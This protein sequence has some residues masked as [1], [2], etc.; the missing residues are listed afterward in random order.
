MSKNTGLFCNSPEPIGIPMTKRI[1]SN[2][3]CTI[4]KLSPSGSYN[5]QPFPLERTTGALAYV[6]T[7]NFA[8]FSITSLLP[9]DFNFNGLGASTSMFRD[10]FTLPLFNGR[11]RLVAGE[12]ES[13]KLGNSL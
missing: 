10:A 7:I 5:L 8:S 4:K 12:T 9:F 13:E 3:S 11:R 2:P 6:A 1:H